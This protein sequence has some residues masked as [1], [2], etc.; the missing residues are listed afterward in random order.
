MLCDFMICY[1]MLRYVMLCYV[2]Q[3]VFHRPV[4]ARA[5]ARAPTGAHGR[6]RVHLT[7]FATRR[8]P[9]QAGKSPPARGSRKCTSTANLRT[10]ILDFRGLVDSSRILVLRGGIPRFIGIFQEMLSQRIFV[11]IILVG[12]LSVRAQDERALRRNIG[13]PCRKSRRPVVLCPYFEGN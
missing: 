3:S 7:P 6:T 9:G 10:R 12:R 13:S 8:Q 4:R 1:V 2:M 5:R 11:W